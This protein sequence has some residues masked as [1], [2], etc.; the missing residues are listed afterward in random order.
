MS[1]LHKVNQD[2]FSER[3]QQQ[4]GLVLVDFYADWCGP[5]QAQTP[6]LE[7]FAEQH[8]AQLQV[9]KV[10]VDDAPEVARAYGVRSIPTLALFA[11]GEVV[12]TRVGTS[13][14]AQLTA[15]I[16]KHVH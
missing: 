14:Q 8:Q 2:D 5:C 13:S 6:V 16:E 9:V 1:H 12:D 4:S 7:S 10:N 15:L 11:D 3:V